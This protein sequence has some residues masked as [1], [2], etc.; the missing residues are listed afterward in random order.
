MGRV[1]SH[2]VLETQNLVQDA[3][4]ILGPERMHCVAPDRGPGCMDDPRNKKAPSLGLRSVT[5]EG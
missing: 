4:E 1:G 5:E 3:K 2:H